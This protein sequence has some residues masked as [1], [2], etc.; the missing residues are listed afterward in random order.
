MSAFIVKAGAKLQE[1]RR[2]TSAAPAVTQPRRS[3][4]TTAFWLVQR[5]RRRSSTSVKAGRL[6]LRPSLVCVI[7]CITSFLP[8]Q[9]DALG[10]N[11]V[12][13]VNLGFGMDGQ[14][15][16]FKIATLHHDDDG[17]ADHMHMVA[18]LNTG[19]GST[20][21]MYIDATFANRGGFTYLYTVRGAN[22][23]TNT[24]LVAYQAS[25]GAPVD[26]YLVFVNFW[27]Q[28]SY[29]ILE[30]MQETIYQNPS[31]TN[32][33]LPPSS[34]IVFDSNNPAYLPVTYSNFSSQFGI[35]TSAPQKMLS[36]AKD[37]NID[38]N[39]TNNGSTVDFSLGYASGEG[40]SS[41]RTAGSPN[42]YGLDFFTG[43]AKRLSVTNGGNVGVGT[44]SPSERL[45]VNGNLK[46]GGNLIFGNG[47]TF[48]PGSNGNAFTG[49]TTFGGT[50]IYGTLGT[51]QIIDSPPVLAFHNPGNTVATIGLSKE[52][53]NHNTFKIRAG[54]SGADGPAGM[55][56]EGAT[57]VGGLLRV[58]GNMNNM[59]QQGSYITWNKLTG[60][61]GETD[62]VNHKG[63]GY[64]GFAFYNTGADGTNRA[65]LAFLDGNSGNFGVGTATPASKLEVNGDIRFTAGPGAGLIFKDSNGTDH[66]QM[67]AWEG[68][69]PG[70]D[71]A[72]SV[73]VVGP[74]S[75]YEPG[76]VLAI[77][78]QHP[79]SF[80]KANAPYSTLVGGIYS[81]RPGLLG[82]RERSAQA[83]SNEV[84]LALNGIVPTK[85]TDENGPIHIGDLLVSS[86]HPGF[87]MR[88]TDKN[89][90][91]GA[92]VGKALGSLEVGNGVIEVLVSLQ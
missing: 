65:L 27:N 3:A 78:V 46:L 15:H 86:S 13:T 63:G 18:T 70:Q 25:A 90:M 67:T 35:G 10:Q 12:T 48:S 76:D 23:S 60:G 54:N 77:D 72:D 43:F 32:G 80:V 73:D 4:P 28:A 6:S 89:R 47:S 91:T 59:N 44:Q 71:Y 61:Y 51:V 57:Y 38:Q 1:L 74:S 82:K 68:T 21:N 62:F 39:D 84:P 31:D 11:Y 42:Q 56:V 29:T 2:A 88:G 81:T 30:S 8:F 66:K 41:A 7:L 49:R 52:D 53:S 87:A 22:N 36:V 5:L 79:R 40:L 9:S 50:S 14:T 75:G 33:V 92:V 16:S 17:D 69:V 19:D 83:A 58:A 85:V 26:I 34:T 20:S 24:R 37:M 55:D 64:G 45:E